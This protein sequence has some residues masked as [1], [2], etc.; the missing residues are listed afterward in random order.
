MH[1]IDLRIRA[2]QVARMIRNIE[3]A[4][5]PLQPHLVGEQPGSEEELQGDLRSAYNGAIDRLRVLESQLIQAGRR[6]NEP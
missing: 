4:R 5:D 6:A 1:V 2:G 3:R